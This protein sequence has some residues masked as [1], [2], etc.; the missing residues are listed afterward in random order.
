MYVKLF[1][2][3]YQGTLRGKS[4]GILVFTN[5]LAHADQSG[6]V[7]IHPRAIA[8]EV[9]LSEDSVRAALGFLEAVDEESR[10]PEN[11]GRRIVLLDGHRAWGWQIVNYGKYR[12]IKNEDDRREQNRLAQERWRTKQAAVSNDKQPSAEISSVSRGKPKQ[13]QKQKQKKENTERTASASRLPDDFAPDF[14]FAVDNG[15][16]NPSEE[17][18]RFRDYWIAQPDA[19][20][21]KLD[22]QATW[23][24]WCRNAKPANRRAATE[25]P[26]QASQRRKVDILTGRNGPQGEV[27]DCQTAFLETP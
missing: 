2:S 25:T 16:Q 1:A 17:A 13:K 19:K 27:I 23:R 12:A 4:D 9:G 11:E 3:L 24:N 18:A 10:S 21:K 20:G 6:R 14:Q 22:W 8:E 26:Y 15:I 5:L 7:D